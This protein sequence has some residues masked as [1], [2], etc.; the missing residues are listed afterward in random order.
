M[1][2]LA[3][4]SSAPGA[5]FG[6]L[7]LLPDDRLARRATLGDKR[8]FEAIYRRYHQ[9]LYRFC[10]AM[11]GS[12]QDAQDTLQN[13]MIKVLQ[14]LPGEERRIRLKP[15]LYRIARNE[16]V[17]T[18]RRR[19][20]SE[21]LEPE[22]MTS[23]SAAE[24]AETR[25]RLRV[26]F[27]DLELLP[28]RQ[29]AVLVMRELSGLDFNQIGAAFETSP[30]VAR[31]TLYEARLNLRRLEEGRAMRCDDVMRELSDADGRVVRR[32]E[33]R[34]HLRGCADCR[35]FR[36]EI[37]TRRVDLAAIAPLP[38]AASA[39]LLHSVFGAQASATAGA[40]VGAAAGTTG[41]G[42]AGTIGTGAGKAVA[43]SALAKSAAT[44]AVVAVVG[45]SAADRSGLVDL[46]LP[47][48]N[49]QSST[50]SIPRPHDSPAGGNA[51]GGSDTAARSRGA[52]TEPKAR[53]ASRGGRGEEAEKM[54]Y[55]GGSTARGKAARDGGSYR[56]Q[57]GLTPPGSGH[58][59]SASKRHGRPDRLP[60]A[61]GHGQQS[62]AAHKPSHTASPPG[63]STAGRDHGKSAGDGGSRLPQPAPSPKAKAPAAVSPA[64]PP[65]A[66]ATSKGDN[67]PAEPAVGDTPDA[68]EH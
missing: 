28:E 44:V 48:K 39:A 60:E 65:S 49:H 21:E 33:I 59:R 38:L 29:R 10:L 23:S 35:A 4:S 46:P 68:L 67:V 25:E 11:V 6:V 14:A 45:V 54:G 53:G 8:A 57:A 24:T 43:T 17:E 12:P 18:L 7:R 63:H 32:H 26:L 51:P 31:Q 22:Q 58:G 40:G 2:E 5:A 37:A 66:E 62:A 52:S 15:W 19:R 20:D 42:L 3:S 1:T 27:A 34:A 41:S 16:A 36:D 50:Q 61:S 56:S 30:A 55:N 64:P 9:D 47:A 13:T